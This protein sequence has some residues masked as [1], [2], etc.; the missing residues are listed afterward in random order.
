MRDFALLELR[1][2]VVVLGG[3]GAHVERRADFVCTR[4]CCLYTRISE[5]LCGNDIDGSTTLVM[6]SDNKRNDAPESLR[7]PSRS[8]GR[9]RL[10]RVLS[11]PR[12]SQYK[13]RR[14]SA[15]SASAICPVVEAASRGRYYIHVV[16]NLRTSM[17]P[18]PILS[19]SE[20]HQ[21]PA[22]KRPGWFGTTGGARALYIV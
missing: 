21:S 3:R 22:S 11:A 8:F 9:R 10:C 18:G 1:C 6:A 16:A 7:Q 20:A 4:L 12:L 15:T 5:W 2:S 13:V 14:K 19:V 17:L